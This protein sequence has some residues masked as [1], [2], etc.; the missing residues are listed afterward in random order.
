MECTTPLPNPNSLL[1]LF[2]T[3]FG[4]GELSVAQSNFT[5]KI[6]FF[7]LQHFSSTLKH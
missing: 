4:L 6:I 1:D 7:R 2:P 3:S 5:Q